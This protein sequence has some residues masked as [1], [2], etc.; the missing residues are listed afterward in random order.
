[1]LPL[2]H[3]R[4]LLAPE[5]VAALNTS[6]RSWESVDLSPGPVLPQQMYINTRGDLAVHF[7]KRGYPRV[8]MA[9]TCLAPD[10]AAWLVLLDKLVPTETVLGQA[11]MVWS[12][13]DLVQVLPFVTPAFLPSTLVKWPPVNWE[14]IARGLARIAAGEDGAAR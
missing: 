14:R 9:N 4:S 13:A 1:M 11:R 3:A 12:K 5:L 2:L 8:L 10:V 7:L 6:L